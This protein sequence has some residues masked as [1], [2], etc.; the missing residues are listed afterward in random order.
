[1]TLF[2]VLLPPGLKRELL[3]LC[4]DLGERFGFEE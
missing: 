2:G 1:M 3:L 4:A